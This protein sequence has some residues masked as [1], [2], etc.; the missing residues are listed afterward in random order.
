MI[1]DIIIILIIVIVIYNVVS[2]KKSNEYDYSQEPR[3]E[4]EIKVGHAP[5]VDFKINDEDVN[6]YNTNISVKYK[7]PSNNI[8]PEMDPQY[9]DMSE[10]VKYKDNMNAMVF[11]GKGLFIPTNRRRKIKIVAFSYEDAIENL[12]SDGFDPEHI[13]I[14]RDFFEPPT[15][16]QLEAMRM[17]NEWI[18]ENACMTD[19]S[20]IISRHM[21]NDR[22]ADKSL[23]DFATKRKLV[24]SYYIGQKNLIKQLLHTFDDKESIAFYVLYV[25]RDQTGEWHFEHFDKY[26]EIAVQLLKNEK[27]MKSFKNNTKIYDLEEKSYRQRTLCYTTAVDIMCK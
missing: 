8:S 6:Q 18:P 27:F 14:E 13:D 2:H 16:N 19:I 5:V 22:N 7:T 11:N 25:E 4:F 9:K 26:K 23:M 21:D 10:R 15:E 24:F 1:L 17:H 3:D 12:I 20:Y